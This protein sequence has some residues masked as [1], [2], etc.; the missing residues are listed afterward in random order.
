[1]SSMNEQVPPFAEL[2]RQTEEPMRSIFQAEADE[3]T[4]G[5]S[6]EAEAKGETQLFKLRKRMYALMQTMS[7]WKAPHHNR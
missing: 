5:V 1:M 6:E 4:N 7:A 2:L 3:Y